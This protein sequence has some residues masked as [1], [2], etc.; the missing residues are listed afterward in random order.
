MS[1]RYVFQSPSITNEKG[2][3][4]MRAPRSTRP[5]LESTLRNSSSIIAN[6]NAHTS[7]EPA[8]TPLTQHRKVAMLIAVLTVASCLCFGTAYYLYTTRGSGEHSTYGYLNVCHKISGEQIAVH[9][10]REC[11]GFASEVLVGHVRR[12]SYGAEIYLIRNS[13][14]TRID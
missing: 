12:A 10:L 9:D 5:V 8:P 1:S 3:Y 2:A 14:S 6:A 7:Y 13:A 4:R 11:I